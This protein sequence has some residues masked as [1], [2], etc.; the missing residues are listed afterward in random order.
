MAPR[1]TAINEVFG[2]LL[3]TFPAEPTDRAVNDL[4][5]S[6]LREV[7]DV[8]PDGVV[9]DI[10]RVTTLDS[11]FARVISDTADM[12]SLMGGDVVIVGTRPSVAITAA[13][14]GYGFED[15]ETARDIDH[16]LS[17]LG[18]AETDDIPDID[19]GESEATNQTGSSASEGVQNRHE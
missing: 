15:I 19:Q 16:A 1:S 17:M 12:V 7:D 13:E 8:Q 6:L 10:S 18:V 9:I 5:E 2:V 4:Q 11:F 3:A 14:L